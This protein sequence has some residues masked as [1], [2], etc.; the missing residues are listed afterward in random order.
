M[1]RTQ[2]MK[3]ADAALTRAQRLAEDAEHYAQSDTYNHKA[4]PFAAAGALWADIARTH[5]TVA[6]TLPETKPTDG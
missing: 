6:A 3:L 5:A 2:H 4:A 1:D